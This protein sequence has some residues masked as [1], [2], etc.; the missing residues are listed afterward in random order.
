MA[1]NRLC[2]SQ[3]Q[4]TSLPDESPL[5]IELAMARSP[6]GHGRARRF[7]VR[8][9]QGPP[10]V[11]GRCHIPPSV[12]VA[13]PPPPPSQSPPIALGRCVTTAAT[14]RSAN[15]RPRVPWQARPALEATHAPRGPHAP[16]PTWP[17]PIG[18]A[19]TIR[20]DAFREIP[21]RCGFSCKPCRRS[22]GRRR[23][24]WAGS[25]LACRTASGR[26]S[27]GTPRASCTC[28]RTSSGSPSPDA[29]SPRTSGTSRR[30]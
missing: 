20:P 5:A 6:H 16:R 9:D 30:R 23:G 3:L 15:R 7:H 22:P 25:P 18:S 21:S 26:T 4:H 14:A 12:L 1:G 13:W 28:R 11:P 17:R 19:Q 8:T 24:S 29:R 10:S 27:R 2:S